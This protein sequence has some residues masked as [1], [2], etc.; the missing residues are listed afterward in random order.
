[1]EKDILFGTLVDAP[2]TVA[3]EPRTRRS[4][5]SRRVQAEEI[6][7]EMIDERGRAIGFDSFDLSAVGVYLYS[8]LLMSP[9]ERVQLRLRLPSSGGPV[10]LEGEVVRA[11]TEGGAQNPGMGV[12]FRGVEPDV[13]EALRTYVA[14]R[15]IRHAGA[16]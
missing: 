13:Q 4:R 6:G 11:E 5:R 14:E 1:M 15:F 2:E 8:D 12:A 16:R 7:I 3:E 9:G 10:A